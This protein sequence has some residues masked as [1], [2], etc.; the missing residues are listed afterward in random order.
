M[1]GIQL[2]LDG[3]TSKFDPKDNAFPDGV[4]PTIYRTTDEKEFLSQ[5]KEFIDSDCSRIYMD[6]VVIHDI[7]AVNPEDREKFDRRQTLD[8]ASIC[9][10]LKRGKRMA[11]K[12]ASVYMTDLYVSARHTGSEME[13]E[14]LELEYP[15]IMFKKTRWE[16]EIDHNTS[17]SKRTAT[18]DKVSR[19]RAKQDD[20]E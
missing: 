12:L 9:V 19:K 4:R 5:L 14:I 17:P 2:E 10:K 11:I 15:R 18:K 20:E 7:M 16:A 8:Y 3:T 13:Y 1:D 6:G